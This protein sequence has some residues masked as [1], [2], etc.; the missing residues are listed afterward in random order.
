MSGTLEKARA[1]SWGGGGGEGGNL[2]AL[3][4]GVMRCCFASYY[5]VYVSYYDV[6]D[7]LTFIPHPF[8]FE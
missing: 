5:D 1:N 4:Y 8:P 3:N 7:A 6:Y 2:Q